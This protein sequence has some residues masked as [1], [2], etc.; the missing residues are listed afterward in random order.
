M[1]RPFSSFAHGAPG[2]G[3]LLLR[4]TAGLTLITHGV[5]AFMTGAP[6]AQVALDGLLIVLGMLLLAGL[7]TPVAGALGVLVCVWEIVV[8]PASELQFLPLATIA[9]ALAL[10]G[11]GAWS[12]DAR[13]YGWTELRISER[14]ADSDFEV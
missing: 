1:R 4:L 2:A 6:G 14:R 3:L 5:G 11:P 7:W 8:H 13:L 9:A 10:L 12:V